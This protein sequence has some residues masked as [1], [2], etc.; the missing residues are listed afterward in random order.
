MWRVIALI[1]LIGTSR[2]AWAASL[3]EANANSPEVG[4]RWIK[5]YRNNPD[6]KQVP[7]LIKT[8]SE[9]GIFADPETSGVYLGF[10]AGVLHTSA[11]NAKSLAA[12][13]LPLSFAD[14]WFLIRA[15]AY[16]GLTDWTKVM[17][18]VSPR[19]P[20]RQLLIGY[21]LTGKLT[22]I[23]EIPLEPEQATAYEQMTRIFE[24]ETYFG[25][26]ED[27]R[28]E[29]TF[30]T[31]PELID[32]HWGIYYATGEDEPIERIVR[33][34][35]WSKERDSVEKLTIGGMAKFTLATNAS[36][37][38]KLLRALKRISTR[39]G[40]AVLRVLM[41]VIIA[42]ET[43]DTG[44][45]KQEALAAIE[46]LRRKGP[47]SKRDIAWWG[48]VGQVTLS[49]G[50]LTAAATGQAEFGL[51]CVIGGAVS[52]AALKYFASPE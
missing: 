34:L 8:L 10:L 32:I 41:E 35:P 4:L 31:H 22:T 46:E 50:C 47:G 29:M 1:I 13:T 33:L 39:Q 40:E 19:M 20:N 9:R 45:I 27:N 28:P 16:S 2:S 24:R 25:E 6:P 51:P 15:I 30:A 12:K 43:V 7:D 42:A 3:A 52:S 48:K 26:K 38:A 44:R 17:L 36:R 37:D 11:R 21:Y 5:D 49:V 23:E 14:Q 18:E